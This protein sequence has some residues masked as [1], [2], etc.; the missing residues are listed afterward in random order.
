MSST[1]PFIWLLFY[2]NT[3]WSNPE[4]IKSF[5]H[6]LDVHSNFDHISPLLCNKFNIDSPLYPHRTTFQID[7]NQHIKNHINEQHLLSFNKNSFQQNKNLL[8][9]TAITIEYIGLNWPNKAHHTICNHYSYTTN[10]TINIISHCIQSITSNSIY[11]YLE[12][13]N[14]TIC[15]SKR[16]ILFENNNNMN[17]LLV[18]KNERANITFSGF[19]F[20]FLDTS[21]ILLMAVGSFSCL[22]WTLFYIV[23]H[24]ALLNFASVN[25][26]KTCIFTVFLASFANITLSVSL[27]DPFSFVPNAISVVFCLLQFSKYAYQLIFNFNAHSFK[28]F[29][30]FKKNSNKNEFLESNEFSNNILAKY[31]PNSIPNRRKRLLYEKQ[32]RL[33]ANL[34]IKFDNEQWMRQSVISDTPSDIAKFKTNNY[35]YK[36]RVNSK[37]RGHGHETY[38]IKIFSIIFVMISILLHEIVVFL[39]EIFESDH[40][41]RFNIIHA[42]LLFQWMLCL[43]FM[44]TWYQNYRFEY[45]IEKLLDEGYSLYYLMK[46]KNA[47]LQMTDNFSEIEKEMN[48]LSMDHISMSNNDIN[49]GSS[50]TNIPLKV[51]NELK[52]ENE[53]SYSSVSDP[54]DYINDIN[55][56]TKKQLIDFE[57]KNSGEIGKCCKCLRLFSVSW[58]RLIKYLPLLVFLNGCVWIFFGAYI[59]DIEVIWLQHAISIGVSGVYLIFSCCMNEKHLILQKE[60]QII[61]RDKDDNKRDQKYVNANNNNNNN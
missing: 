23:Y 53:D 1:Q 16:Q 46:D 24:V 6:Q 61:K 41:T 35:E 52:E 29:I 4:I 11:Y 13:H 26:T 34:E 55:E 50:G 15:Y 3:V 60:R 58:L 43:C 45:A 42:L 25:F 7:Y 32:E 17:K 8:Q 37:Y 5:Y 54:D 39:T 9:Y 28:K 38:E 49:L 44:I 14:S 57:E 21:N 59:C 19:A 40:T 10:I 33:K 30:K 47:K 20:N 22:F 31:N 48:T 51:S 27:Q 12:D 2:I 56:K 18:E 36:S